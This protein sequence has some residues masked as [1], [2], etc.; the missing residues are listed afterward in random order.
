MM[1]NEFDASMERIHAFYASPK[2]KDAS[3]HLQKYLDA[4]YDTMKRLPQYEFELTCKELVNDLSPMKRPMAREFNA[5]RQR[6][7]AQ[8]RTSQSP[9][10]VEM[11]KADSDAWC[12]K[13]AR[14]MGPLGA[15]EVLKKIDKDGIVMPDGVVAA[16][17]ESAGKPMPPRRDATPEAQLVENLDKL[18]KIKSA[19]RPDFGAALGGLQTP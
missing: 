1:R 11:T 6:I 7:A 8:F 9:G 5:A 17:V 16:L 19:T 3:A 13:E 12:L 4:L 2:D 14:N 10:F 18:D 15:Q